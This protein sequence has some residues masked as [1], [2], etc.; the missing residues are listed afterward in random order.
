MLLSKKALLKNPL[1]LRALPVLGLLAL[2]C[3][4]KVKAV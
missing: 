3:G 4:G 2:Q 1:N